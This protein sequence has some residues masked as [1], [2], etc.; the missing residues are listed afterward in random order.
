MEDEHRHLLG[1]LG[2]LL[3]YPRVAPTEAARE[4]A[5]LA[6]QRD[7]DAGE[8]LGEFTTFAEHSTPEHI[9]EVY[10][11]T[12]DLDAS[13]HPYVGY[14]LFGE[15]Y[16][17]SVFMVELKERY[18]AHSYEPN[19]AEELPDH[20]P[21]VLGFVARCDDDEAVLEI[22]TEA[23]LPTVEKMLKKGGESAESE[24]AAGCEAGCEAAPGDGFLTGPD[25][26]SFLTG[27]GEDLENARPEKKEHTAVGP[28]RALLEALR[29]LLRVMTGDE[30]PVEPEGTPVAWVT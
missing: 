25:G 14:H 9:Q 28:Y 22:A 5:R 20:L 23:L 29:T 27:Q 16:Q 4:S 10:T 11:D 17:R 18:K 21:V 24:P 3:E 7:E 12:F 26:Q 8:L 1:L 15:T 30:R 13:C 19:D 6:A 2:G